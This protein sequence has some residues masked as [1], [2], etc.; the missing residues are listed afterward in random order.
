MRQLSILISPLAIRVLDI[1]PDDVSWDVVVVEVSV[2]L[3]HVLLISVVPPTLKIGE[4]ICTAISVMGWLHGEIISIFSLPIL[5]TEIGR[6][7]QPK[8]GI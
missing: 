2:D 5:E 4:R 1:Q 6:S 3:S 7:K 8:I